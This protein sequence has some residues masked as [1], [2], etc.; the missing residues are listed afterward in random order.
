MDYLKFKLRNKQKTHTG[1]KYFNADLQEE[2]GELPVLAANADLKKQRVFIPKTG[3][4]SFQ[5]FQFRPG[6]KWLR[7]VKMSQKSVRRIKKLNLI[8][9]DS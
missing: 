8:V 7:P 1:G 9:A 2:I 3:D 4:Y 6:T 5:K